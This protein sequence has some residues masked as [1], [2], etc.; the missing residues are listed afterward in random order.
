MGVTLQTILVLSA[1]WFTEGLPFVPL[2]LTAFLPDLQP[3]LRA[4]P[5]VHKHH[6]PGAFSASV[7]VLPFSGVPPSASLPH[8]MRF[9][10][11]GSAPVFLL[12]ASALHCEFPLRIPECLYC[13]FGCLIRL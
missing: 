10:G 9:C 3:T 13:L 2:L 6:I 4:L 7:S 8:G 11:L 12:F 5:I 1:S